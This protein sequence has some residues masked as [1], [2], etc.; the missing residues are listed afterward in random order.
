MK[1]AQRPAN[2]TYAASVR[3]EPSPHSIYRRRVYVS[4]GGQQIEWCI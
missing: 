2:Y 4:L 3:S 1:A